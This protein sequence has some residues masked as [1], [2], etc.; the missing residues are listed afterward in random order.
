MANGTHLADHLRTTG[1]DRFEFVPGRPIP[2]FDGGRLTALF[3]AETMRDMLP[4]IPPRK[5]TAE[6]VEARA[7]AYNHARADGFNHKVSKCYFIGAADGPV[8]IGHAIDPASRLKTLQAGSPVILSI[9]ATARGGEA[10]E[11]A[12][13][14]Q[15]AAHRLHGEWFARCPAI[16]AEIARLTPEAGPRTSGKRNEGLA[17]ERIGGVRD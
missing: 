2:Y 12:Y 3:H 11:G 9:L 4:F 8:K 16:L 5:L 6:E 14:S 10:R 13:H 7:N 17:I 1:I 15:F